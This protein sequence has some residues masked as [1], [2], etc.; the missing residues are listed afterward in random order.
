L[1]EDGSD[2]HA[3]HEENEQRSGKNRFQFHDAGMISLRCF[4]CWER[5]FL[6]PSARH[7]R[8]NQRGLA[9]PIPLFRRIG[10][11]TLRARSKEGDC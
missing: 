3:R 5:F 2:K 1:G 4:S 10:R 7:A 6:R 9:F 8:S 11:G